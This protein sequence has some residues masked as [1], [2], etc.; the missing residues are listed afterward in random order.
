MGKLFFFFC[1]PITQS[2]SR[3][4]IVIQTIPNTLNGSYFSFFSLS[5]TTKL[6]KNLK[7]TCRQLGKGI[8]RDSQS[9]L[10]AA[11][12]HPAA[13]WALS[14]AQSTV[15]LPWHSNTWYLQNS[16]ITHLQSNREKAAAAS[17]NK[18]RKSSITVNNLPGKHPVH[19]S[20]LCFLLF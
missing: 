12:H 19:R 4:Q 13:S 10:Q 8:P 1:L 15:L 11:H 17:L 6:E 18:P 5:K 16:L 2:S 20:P 7:R 9:R 14:R 3:I